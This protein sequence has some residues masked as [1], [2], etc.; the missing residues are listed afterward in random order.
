MKTQDILAYVYTF[1]YFAFLAGVTF[2]GFEAEAKDLMNM[3]VGILSAA[4]LAIIGYYFGSS[5]GSAKKTE[6]LKPKP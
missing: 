1:G 6:L 3:L 2:Y 5:E 4:Q